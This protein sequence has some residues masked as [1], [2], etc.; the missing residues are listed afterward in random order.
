MIEESY[1]VNTGSFS[2]PLDLLLHLI[3]RKK[4]DILN[5]SIHEI[6]AEYLGYLEHLQGI[7][8]S[9]EGDFL[10]TAATLIYLKSRSLLPRLEAEDGEEASP[11]QEFLH[12]LIEYDKI[13]KISGLLREME[14][15]E[16]LF[17]SRD[18]FEE[19]FGEVE[20]DL[21]EVSSFQLAEVFYH[22]LRKKEQED[23]RVVPA[24]EYSMEE[25]RS[26]I[27]QIIRREGYL[28]FN[29]Y[30]RDCR[31]LV[32]III[33]LFCILEIVKQKAATAV[34][35]TRFGTISVFKRES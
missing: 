15:E 18:R 10:M 21:K 16:L 13:Q 26:E 17:W 34:Q 29:E 14:E 1:Q 7:D 12:T 4:M 8:P 35:K 33:T 9:R 3:R 2:G 24:K 27:L 23:L 28:N 11:E 31:S 22:I 32:E 30:I 25:K 20:Y 5:I 19:D 6:T